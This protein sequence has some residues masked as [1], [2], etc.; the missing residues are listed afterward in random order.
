MSQ[1]VVI[2]E[3]LRFHLFHLSGTFYNTQQFRF[4]LLFK[5]IRN[6]AI[7]E[8]FKMLNG[9]RKHAAHTKCNAILWHI[10]FASTDDDIQ[11][12]FI[13]L[14]GWCFASF[15]MMCVSLFAASFSI[16]LFLSISSLLNSPRYRIRTLL[17]LRHLIRLN[18][19]SHFNGEYQFSS[20]S[21][22][23]L[24]IYWARRLSKRLW[25]RYLH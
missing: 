25:I 4:E 22:Q 1:V 5:F 21:Y 13:I 6:G 10:Y 19:L 7:N 12:D 18:F 14:D 15:K 23:L 11:S 17:H 16:P 8:I 9:P 20:T 24:S 2:D 3:K